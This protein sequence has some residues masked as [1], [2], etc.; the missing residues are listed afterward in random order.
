MRPVA[1]TGLG[2]ISSIGNTADEVTRSLK[3]GRSGVGVDQERI[4]KGF[5]SSLTGQIKDFKPQNW[6]LNRKNLRTMCEPAMFACAAAIDAVNDAGLLE[7]HI[8]S[9]RC[10]LIFGNDSTVKASVESI[11]LAREHNETHYIGAGSI[12][13][14]MNSTV[15]MN[16]AS[17]F[18]IRG[19]NWTLSAAC[20]SG[21]HVIGQALMLIRSGFQDIVIAGGAQEL[22]WMSMASFDSLGAFSTRHDKP[23]KASRPFDAQRDGLV[24]SGGGATLVIE[25]LEHARKRGAHIYCTI[26]G[27]GFSSL[28]ATNLSEPSS[29][30]SLKAMENALADAALRP[31]QVDYINAH[32]TSTP[33][34]DLAEAIAINEIFGAKTPVT[35]TKSLTGHECWMAGASEVIYTILMAKNGFISPNL[36]FERLQEDCPVINVISDK[37][38]AGIDFALSNSFGFGGTNAALLL[39]FT[40]T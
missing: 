31:E 7:H 30:A 18:G 34:G 20:A 21:A 27:Y 26:G 17:Y 11:D 35:S 15:T 10:G 12:F 13:R 5:K 33:L 23:H 24:P 1:V 36:N 28:A 14:T 37:T 38:D 3:E 29:E 19:A 2:I 8:Q 6:G 40:T 25:D 39:D 32:A 9:D 16:L 4:D 22:N